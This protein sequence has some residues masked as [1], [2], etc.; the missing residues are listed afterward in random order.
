MAPPQ[1]RLA[2]GMVM[3]DALRRS[4]AFL[5]DDEA[6]VAMAD[7]IA[8]FP[9]AHRVETLAPS[10]TIADARRILLALAGNSSLGLLHGRVDSR[11]LVAVESRLQALRHPDAGLFMT[12]SGSTGAPK[13][14]LLETERIISHAQAVND[15][16][17]AHSGDCWLAC[18]PFYHV[19][20]MAILPRAVLSGA[21][22]RVTGNTNA[23]ELSRIID[24]EPIT[25]TSLVPTVLRRLIAVRNGRPFPGRLRAILVGGGPVPLN[26]TEQVPQALRTYGMT[27]AGSMV[28]C[29]S[30]AADA[31]ERASSGR[32]IRGAAVRVVNDEFQDLPCGETGRI[33]VQSAGMVTGYVD[34][35]NQTALV[36]REG[37]IAS[38]D[39]GSLDRSGCLHVLGRRDRIIISGGENVALDEVESALRELPDVREAACIGLED[40]EWGQIVAAA[41]EAERSSL[42]AEW[43][44]MLRERLPGFKLPRRILTT[45]SLPHLPNG[46]LDYRAVRELFL[47]L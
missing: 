4:G 14:M 38:E 42:S 20:G 16:L 22:V 13:L 27:E 23:A 15:H 40:E 8:S 32:A 44:N 41:V 34:D 17:S 12:S 39:I 11:E 21:S 31:A 37:W 5:Q 1:I 30:L 10:N 29:V 28:T 2:S 19:G 9:S 35:L 33:L 47:N 46:K 6:R 36:F 26:L 3:R 24:E 25:L 45:R 18:L 43:L 7:L